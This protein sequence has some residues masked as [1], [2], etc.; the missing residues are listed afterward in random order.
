MRNPSNLGSSPCHVFGPTTRGFRWSGGGITV[1]RAVRLRGLRAGFSP[2][3]KRAI[4]HHSRVTHMAPA[5]P[6]TT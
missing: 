6:G 5:R 3:R 1:A 4:S 2:S